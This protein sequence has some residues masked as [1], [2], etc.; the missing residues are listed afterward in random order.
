MGRME[1]RKA[2][3]GLVVVPPVDGC[4]GGVAEDEEEGVGA[5]GGGVGEGETGRRRKAAGLRRR[6]KLGLEGGGGEVEEEEEAT[7]IVAAVRVAGAVAAGAFLFSLSRWA[8]SVRLGRWRV[9]VR[10]F[11]LLRFLG[12]IYLRRGLDVIGRERRLFEVG[13][14]CFA[15]F[16]VGIKRSIFS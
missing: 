14:L 8:G 6:R 1:E 3:S 2:I 7:S 16:W 12:G 15:R 5:G 9:A 4:L 10:G 13:C 11:C